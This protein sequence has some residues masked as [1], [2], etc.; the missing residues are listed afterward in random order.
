VAVYHQSPQKAREAAEGLVQ[1]A[2]ALAKESGR[3][4][5]GPL[6]EA[7][8]AE[9][10]GFWFTYFEEIR[11]LDGVRDEDIGTWW[12][13]DEVERMLVGVQ[14][15]VAQLGA[16]ISAKQQGL[17]DDE[18]TVRARQTLP[19][20]GR[21]GQLVSRWREKRL[22]PFELTGRVTRWMETNAPRTAPWP[23]DGYE[24]VNDWVR[25]MAVRGAL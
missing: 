9:K 22:L 7:M 5:R 10:S 17:S 13:R 19:Y 18:A 12:N 25:E 16:W 14:G 2:I 8:L 6:G 21:P 24:T 15:E 3:Y 1:Q 23:W 20:Y 4:G 11:A